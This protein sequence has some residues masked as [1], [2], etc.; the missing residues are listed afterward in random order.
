MGDVNYF[1]IFILAFGAISARAANENLLSNTLT[2]KEDN[3]RAAVKDD[4]KSAAANRNEKNKF[5]ELF[6]WKLSDDLKLTVVEEKKFS[7]FIRDLNDKK[8]QI[9]NE[10]DVTVQDIAKAI[11]S[12]NQNKNRDIEKLLTQYRKNIKNYNDLS[13]KELDG[14]QKIV[15]QERTAQYLVFKSDLT[16]KLKQLLSPTEKNSNLPPPKVIQE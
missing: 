1:F 13:L 6:I 7:E 5:E 9:N 2:I 16:N 8:T 14:V 3:T 11:N 10:I 12:K 4:H 15:G